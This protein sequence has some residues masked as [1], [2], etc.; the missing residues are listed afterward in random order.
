MKVRASFTRGKRVPPVGNGDRLEFD[1]IPAY[2]KLAP[3]AW[4][5]AQCGRS[6][7]PR[8]LA[9]QFPGEQITRDN[10]IGSNLE[11]QHAHEGEI[12]PVFQSVPETI[13]G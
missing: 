4:W 13:R 7:E 8:A 9:H 2:F 3:F 5:R 10:R 6:G 11:I 1:E 12:G